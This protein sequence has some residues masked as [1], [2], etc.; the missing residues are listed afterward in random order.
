VDRTPNRQLSDASG[1]LFK[2]VRSAI[3]LDGMNG[4]EPQAIKMK[5]FDSIHGVLNNELPDDV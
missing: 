1:D 4:V 5:F 2:Y 3:V